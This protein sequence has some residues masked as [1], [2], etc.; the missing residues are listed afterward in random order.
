MPTLNL[1]GA[2]I[3]YNEYGKEQNGIQKQRLLFIHGL[4]SSSLAWRDIPEALSGNFHTI[5][6]DLIGFGGSDKPEKA[7]YTIKGFSRFITDFLRKGIQI[8][9]DEK[10]C[11]VGH[12]LGGYIAS[13]IA[14][15]NKEIIEKIVLI[16]SSGMLDGPTPLLKQYLAAATE[17][18]PIIRY[19]KI[20]RVFEDMYASPSRLLP[21]VIDLFN[22]VIEKPGAKHAFESAFFNSTTTKIESER[23]M[24]IKNI[25]C[26]IIWGI[27][28]NLIPI[29]Y[30]N[31]FTQVLQQAKFEKIEDAGHSPFVEKTAKVYERLRTFLTNKT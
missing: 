28:D 20:K 19:D 5:A 1:N 26:L 12:S 31:R 15:E 22:Y 23:L 10:I 6:V 13:E 30:A 2:N 18:N 14:I 25:P 3:F 29:E 16:D 8:R 7:D 4:G 17:I 24:Q 27:E 11:I 9:N 21:L